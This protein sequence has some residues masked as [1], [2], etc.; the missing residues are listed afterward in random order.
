MDAAIITAIS[1]VGAAVVTGTF[2]YFTTRKKNTADLQGTINEGF[3]NL[4]EKLSDEVK[5]Q[6]NRVQELD[7]DV[8]ALRI[9]VR[10]C[11]VT[12]WH[13][14]EFIHDQGLVVPPIPEGLIIPVPGAAV[15]DTRQAR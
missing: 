1:V 12:I 14:Q 8:I 9:E 6:T 15:V 13:L 7:D 3:T 10:N 4:V 2:L 11:Q 5:R